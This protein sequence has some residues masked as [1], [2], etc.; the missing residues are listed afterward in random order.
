MARR[1]ESGLP[2]V[3]IRPMKPTRL[4]DT[5]QHE[6]YSELVV[7]LIDDFQQRFE[8]FRKHSDVMKLLSDLF[9]VD[10]T[11]KYQTELADI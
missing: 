2:V 10:P 3:S 9:K 7:K 6:K 4:T 5:V 11:V 8:G 1:P